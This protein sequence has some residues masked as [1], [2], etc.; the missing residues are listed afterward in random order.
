MVSTRS[1]FGII[2]V[3]LLCSLCAEGAGK[4]MDFQTFVQLKE[5]DRP[6]LHQ[7]YGYGPGRTPLD[8]T[9]WLAHWGGGHG[10]HFDEFIDY[11]HITVA[12]GIPYHR[13]FL[14]GLQDYPGA[15]KPGLVVIRARRD[16]SRMTCKMNIHAFDKHWGFRI[17]DDQLVDFYPQTANKVEGVERNTMPWPRGEWTQWHDYIIGFD[18]DHAWVS[19]DGRKDLTM[20]LGLN[21]RNP[22]GYKHAVRD[23]VTDSSPI[24]VPQRHEEEPYQDRREH[25]FLTLG[26]PTSGGIQRHMDVMSVQFLPLDGTPK[27]QPKSQPIPDGEHVTRFP[28]GETRTRGIYKGGKEDGPFTSW[29]ANGNRSSQGRFVNGKK[30]GVWSY[31]FE[32]GQFRD[33]ITYKDGLFHGP[34]HRW[35]PNGKEGHSFECENNKRKG[36]VRKWTGSPGQGQSP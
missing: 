3:L 23:R 16:N 33:Q 11:F 7:F 35:A 28:A 26:N 15:G 32:N 2:L 30:E 29:F 34:F 36:E 24:L 13:S 18:G 10:T 17:R 12:G 1:F 20:E 27:A 5:F 8:R 4:K 6:F 25:F 9:N 31:W 21:P 14:Y 19:I 22:K